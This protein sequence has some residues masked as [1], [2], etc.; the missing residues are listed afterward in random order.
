MKIVRIKGLL[1]SY[2]IKKIT[3]VIIYLLIQTIY[4]H[5]GKIKSLLKIEEIVRKQ[6]KLCK[7]LIFQI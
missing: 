5:S 7:F 2:I 3:N 4:S 1:N 6:T